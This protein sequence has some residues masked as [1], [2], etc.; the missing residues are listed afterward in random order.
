MAKRKRKTSGGGAF[1]KAGA[2]LRLPLEEVEDFEEVVRLRGGTRSE[3]YTAVLTRRLHAAVQ[4]SE[5][6]SED[7]SVELAS[8]SIDEFLERHDP[9]PESHFRALAHLDECREDDTPAS[10]RDRISEALA[11]DPDC[12][13]ALLIRS[14]LSEDAEDRLRYLREAV[15]AGARKHAALEA[16]GDCAIEVLDLPY[17]EALHDLGDFLGHRGETEEAV[18][19]TRGSSNWILPIPSMCFRH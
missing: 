14:E 19:P 13:D 3:R 8:L 17:R 15:E 4:S 5:E 7:F 12:V 2:K 16:S 1:G 18:K 6:A 9:E 11:I 10:I